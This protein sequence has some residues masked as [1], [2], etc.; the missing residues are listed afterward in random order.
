MHPAS[1]GPC[2]P[3]DEHRVDDRLQQEPG[4][5]RQ[6]LGGDVG[7]HRVGARGAL[8]VKHGPAQPPHKLFWL[9][10]IFLSATPPG[11]AVRAQWMVCI[12]ISANK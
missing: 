12:V 2:S 6:N 1:A 5:L 11:Q 9:T 4:N 7:G 8:T 10:G 3:V